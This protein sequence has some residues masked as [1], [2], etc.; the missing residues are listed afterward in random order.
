MGGLG[1]AWCVCFAR[2]LVSVLFLICLIVW[3][4]G[5]VGCCLLLRLFVMVGFVLWIVEGCCVY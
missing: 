2:V 1:L 5:N 4:I 3:F